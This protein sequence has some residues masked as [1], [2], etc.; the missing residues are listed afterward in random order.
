MRQ[1]ASMHE[2]RCTAGRREV[3]YKIRTASAGLFWC[4]ERTLRLSRKGNTC[5]VLIASPP[6]PVLEFFPYT[7]YGSH[8]RMGMA[9]SNVPGAL[10][11]FRYGATRCD[12]IRFSSGASRQDVVERLPQDWPGGGLLLWRHLCRLEVEPITYHRRRSTLRRRNNQSPSKNGIGQ[13]VRGARRAYAS[14]LRKRVCTK[15]ER[16]SGADAESVT[17]YEQGAGV[18]FPFCRRVT[19]RSARAVPVDGCG[20]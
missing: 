1:R 15:P 2:D 9:K 12:S 19:N 11:K 8:R 7:N 18:Q 3:C 13:I 14:T 17:K 20:G 16:T 10:H 5:S 6:P 4:T